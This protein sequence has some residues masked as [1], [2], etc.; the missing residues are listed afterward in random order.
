MFVESILMASCGIARG[1]VFLVD[2]VFFV[3]PLTTIFLGYVIFAKPRWF[4]DFV[5][6]IYDEE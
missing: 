5:L 6:L 1:A 3:V 2:I 4:R